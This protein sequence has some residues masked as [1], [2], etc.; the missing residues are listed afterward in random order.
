MLSLSAGKWG[1]RSEWN[2]NSLKP[3]SV[4][5]LQLKQ[6]FAPKILRLLALGFI[7]LASV[8]L[9]LQSLYGQTTMVAVGKVRFA[10]GKTVHMEI[11]AAS[12]S[13][14]AETITVTLSRMLIQ[15]ILKNENTEFL[16]VINQRGQK[17][18]FERIY[19]L[20]L[21]EE[22]V[23][24][25][26]ETSSWQS[27]AIGSDPELIEMIGLDRWGYQLKQPTWAQRFAPEARKFYYQRGT[28]DPVKTIIDGDGDYTPNLYIL[29]SRS[30]VIGLRR[31]GRSHLT[32]PQFFRLLSL[33]FFGLGLL[34]AGTAFILYKRTSFANLGS[35]IWDQVS[36]R[37]RKVS[38]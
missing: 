35:R 13:R 14:P 3:G 16:A 29:D 26:P 17:F 7:F 28:F 24:Q 10:E 4:K 37:G 34:L 31:I 12:P 2:I 21:P 22:A 23:L 19:E 11:A 30:R 20:E 5:F 9:L 36:R 1:G 6:L 15:S 18:Y 8:F 25:G 32:L 38:T 27:I 33:G